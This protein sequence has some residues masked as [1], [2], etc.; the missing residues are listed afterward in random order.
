MMQKWKYLLF[1]L[2]CVYLLWRGIIPGFT[3]IDS[4][5]PNYYVSSKLL[6]DGGGTDSLY[7]DKWFQKQID[8]QG[9]HQEGK[10]SPFPPPTVFLFIPFAWLPPLAALQVWTV[11][12]IL[13]LAV[14]IW[15]ISQITR[16]DWIWSSC[17]L[18]GS[19]HAIINNFRLGQ[20]Y[21]VITFLTLAAYV[22][23]SKERNFLAGF[24]LG[25]GAAFKY[26]PAIFLPAYKEGRYRNAIIACVI[27]I[28]AVYLL[29]IA[30]LGAS[31]HQQFFSSVFVHHLSGDIQNPF[32]FVF[33]SWNG[34]L[35][36]FFVFDS[37]LNPSPMID[38]PLF[39]K[40]I[41]YVIYGTVALSTVYAFFK[42][43]DAA[44]IDEFAAEFALL[45]ITALTLLPASA[46]YHY[47]LLALP[48]ALLLTISTPWSFE[49]KAIL[50]LYFLIGFIPYGLL[51]EFETRGLLAV[52]AFPRLL[53]MTLIFF[54]SIKFI[55][56][57][58]VKKVVE[59]P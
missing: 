59:P 5:F 34:L 1:G 33:Q 52:L 2:L 32:S 35:N 42:L 40:L 18:L 22:L 17:F 31:V 12:N 48:V 37:Q 13:L 16:W 10:F 11:I 19:G 3:K 4:D 58:K 28:V 39:S 41:L 26:F 8:A 27:S 25:I 29:S 15:L 51:G 46:T 54:F 56:G 21:L 49:Q 23:T 53:C 14:S 44:H 57:L 55:Y 36:R 24:L 7:E 45:G 30:I 38:A 6:I 47:L 43:R 50:T 20:F 9:M